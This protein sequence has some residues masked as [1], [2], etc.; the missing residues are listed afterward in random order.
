MKKIFIGGLIALG[1]VSG[2]FAYPGVASALESGDTITLLGSSC[3]TTRYCSSVANVDQN[4]LSHVISLSM[5]PSYTSMYLTVDGV[6]Y[7]SPVGG[8]MGNGP[9]SAVLR[10]AT[11][12]SVMLNVTFSSSRHQVNMGRLHMWVTNWS[13]LSGSVTK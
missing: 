12:E 6:S 7:S 2:G 13:I 9:F 8:G 3:S 4:G 10:S 1:L 5:S 11:G